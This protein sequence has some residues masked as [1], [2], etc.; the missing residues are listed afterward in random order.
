MF[1]INGWGIFLECI[2]S[3]GP[4]LGRKISAGHF[5]IR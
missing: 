1:K 2:F 5:K 4:V 3:G